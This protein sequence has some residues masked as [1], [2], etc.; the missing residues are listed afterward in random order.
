MLPLLRCLVFRSHCI[1]VQLS[2]N[3]RGVILPA[4]LV[5]DILFPITRS[6]NFDSRDWWMPALTSGNYNKQHGFIFCFY[7]VISESWRGSKAR[8]WGVYRSN[9]EES[10]AAQP[11]SARLT[12]CGT[13]QL[14][15][16]TFTRHHQETY[17][18][19][20]WKRVHQEIR[21]RQKKLRLFGVKQAVMWF[22]STRTLTLS[23]KT[24]WW[25]FLLSHMWVENFSVLRAEFFT[26]IHSFFYLSLIGI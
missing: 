10:K 13:T 6:E 21:H 19:P 8:D 2:L 1:S 3:T 5:F 25:T 23:A 11:Q 24:I 4:S 18:G 17:R 20:H 26:E 15:V 14:Q 22:Y 12:S 16:P 7:S 9:H